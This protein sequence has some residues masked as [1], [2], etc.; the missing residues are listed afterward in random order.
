VTSVKWPQ[1]QPEGGDGGLLAALNPIKA[2]VIWYKEPSLVLFFG[3]KIG[4]SVSRAAVLAAC[5]S[6]WVERGRVPAG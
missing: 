6:G 3:A 5:F 1:A 2:G 4:V